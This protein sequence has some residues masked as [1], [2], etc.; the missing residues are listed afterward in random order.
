MLACMAGC[1]DLALFIWGAVLRWGYEGAQCAGDY[2]LGADIR[3]EPY[4]WQSGTFM[5][6][7]VNIIWYLTLFIIVTIC[8]V[9][10][11]MAN[12]EK[13]QDP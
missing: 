1:G 10:C 13:N 11:I 8:C 6:I 9:G 7:Y 5:K 12:Q 4:L 2:Y 3:P